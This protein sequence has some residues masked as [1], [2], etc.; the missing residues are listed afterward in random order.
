MK[1]MPL[2]NIRTKDYWSSRYVT[3]IGRFQQK[4]YKFYY[5]KYLPRTYINKCFFSIF[6]KYILG[7]PNKKILEIG[8]APGWRLR[9]FK[10]RFNADVYGVELTKNGYLLNR[11][12]F[13]SVG[14]NPDQCFHKDFRDAEFQNKYKESFNVV[15]SFGFIEHFTDTDRILGYH[16][17]LLKKGGILIIYIPNLC[18]INSFLSHIFCSKKVLFGHNKNI[19]DLKNFG[20]LFNTLELKTM[21]LDYFG[22]FDLC[23]FMDNTNIWRR[24]LSILM[25]SIQAIIDMLF[26]IILRGKN[27][28]CKFINPGLMYIGKK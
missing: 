19:M 22:T 2:D 18:Y 8:S 20:N 26:R 13:S 27:I 7:L 28:R 25:L 14:I 21:H 24:I 11:E 23:L 3:N 1:N 12:I 4:L 15:M 16:L 6:K 10:S 9:E 5:S 17:N